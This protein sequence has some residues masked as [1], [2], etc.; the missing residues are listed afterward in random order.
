M[1]QYFTIWS[2]GRKPWSNWQINVFERDKHTSTVQE[3]CVHT[4]NPAQLESVFYQPIPLHFAV[5]WSTQILKALWRQK[6]V[7]SF[8]SIDF[9]L[10]SRSEEKRLI[11]QKRFCEKDTCGEKRQ[12]RRILVRTTSCPVPHVKMYFKNS[13]CARNRLDGFTFSTLS[14][15]SNMIHTLTLSKICIS[16]QSY[17]SLPE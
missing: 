2:Q 5:C 6:R 1:W 10:C 9:H 4:L 12:M 13:T 16:Q 17:F 15:A 11:G 3:E 8:V 14:F 7:W